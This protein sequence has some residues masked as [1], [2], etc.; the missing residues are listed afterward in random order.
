MDLRFSTTEDP[1]WL[2]DIRKREIKIIA[3]IGPL[4]IIKTYTNSREKNIKNKIK[5]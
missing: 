2:K 5:N 4:N 1:K 3:K